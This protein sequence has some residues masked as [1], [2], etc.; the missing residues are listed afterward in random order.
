M[1]Y[2]LYSGIGQILCQ[3]FDRDPKARSA[4]QNQENDFGRGS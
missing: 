1:I 2:L 4:R 3:R